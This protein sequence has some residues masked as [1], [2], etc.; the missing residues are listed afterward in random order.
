MADELPFG[1]AAAA[2]VS[3]DPPYYHL[4]APDS[5]TKCTRALDLTPGGPTADDNTQSPYGVP[6]IDF[7]K[8]NLVPFFTA[9]GVAGKPARE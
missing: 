3:S 2:I 1:I 9:K 5:L 8:Q 7:V 4:D 6:L